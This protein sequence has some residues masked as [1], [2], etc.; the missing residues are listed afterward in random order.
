MLRSVDAQLGDLE[1][2]QAPWGICVLHLC[3]VFHQAA[4]AVVDHEA[5]T[6]RLLLVDTDGG[7]KVRL[8][9]TCV[10]HALRCVAPCS[11]AAGEQD[12]AIQVF[13]TDATNALSVSLVKRVVHVDNASSAAQSHGHPRFSP[14]GSSAASSRRAAMLAA[15]TTLSLGER[16]L[17]GRLVN[18]LLGWVWSRASSS[19]IAPR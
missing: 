13:Y 14:H 15:W 6:V 3:G 4:R 10:G 8:G 18:T 1:R 7:C 17:I 19:R 11:P 5:R 16:R 2:L 12:F 9:C